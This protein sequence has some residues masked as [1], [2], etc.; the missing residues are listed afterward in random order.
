ML[1]QKLARM[2]TAEGR[3]V[4]GSGYST[5]ECMDGEHMVENSMHVRHQ[6]ERASL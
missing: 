3:E 6:L 2:A 4:V 1:G 5:H